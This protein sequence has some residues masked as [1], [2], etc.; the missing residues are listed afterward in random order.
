MHKDDNMTN[1]KKYMDAKLELR[2]K[3][4]F[5]PSKLGLE[6]HQMK[7][8]QGMIIRSRDVIPVQNNFGNNPLL[9]IDLE[10]SLNTTNRKTNLKEIKKTIN[11]FKID[12]T[13][14]EACIKLKDIA[15]KSLIT[16]K[17]DLES[18][19][20]KMRY[21]KDTLYCTKDVKNIKIIKE[22]FKKI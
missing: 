10:P 13:N 11:A 21:G 5:K 18:T 19:K 8:G 3:G 6:I 2:N 16:E 14:N 4:V 15:I 1:L 22:K 7:Q 9:E 12:T 17:D 20:M